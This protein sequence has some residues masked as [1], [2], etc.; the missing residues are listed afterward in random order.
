MCWSTG[1]ILIVTRPATIIRSDCRGLNRIASAPNRARSYR[2]DAVAISSMPQHAVANGIGQSELRRAQ[3]TTFLS[4]VVRTL[5]GSACGSSMGVHGSRRKIV[6]LM[7]KVS[8]RQRAPRE[9]THEGTKR[10]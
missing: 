7:Y 8:P 1:I 3:L 4:W 6:N 5:S 2:D 10:Q 9:L